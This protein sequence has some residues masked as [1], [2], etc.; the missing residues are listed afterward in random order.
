[1]R[2]ILAMALAMVMASCNSGNGRLTAS[3]SGERLICG[4]S[5]M[6]GSKISRVREIGNSACGF[7]DA[8]RVSSIAG[9]EI[10]GDAR[11]NCTTARSLEAWTT[12]SAIPSVKRHTNETLESMTMW[13]S[14]ACRSRSS[15]NKLSEHAKGNAVDIANFKTSSGKTY[16][17]AKDW[18]KGAMGR[19]LLSMK[20]GACGPF[21]VVLHPDN[22]R[23]HKDHF[24][25]DTSNRSGRYLYCKENP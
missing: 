9:V 21:G 5:L 13:V 18:R 24:H 10:L 14:Y 12:N 1:M 2:I 7:G 11:M 19:A 8:V 4:S 3:G 16:S 6:K 17:I 25:F 15:S 20:K 23:Y 22:D